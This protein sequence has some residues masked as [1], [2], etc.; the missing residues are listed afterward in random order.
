MTYPLPTATETHNIP[1]D[2]LAAVCSALGRDTGPVALHEPEFRGSEL[3]YVSDCIE[4]GWVSSV[5]KYVDRFEADLAS[6]T[7]VKRAVAVVNGTAALHIALKLVGVEPGDEVL[8]PSLTFIATANAVTYAGAVPHFVDSEPCS[9]GVDANAL[10]QHLQRIA[11]VEVGVCRNRETGARIK[12]LMPMHVFGHP[13]DVDAVYALCERWHLEFVE[14][15][16]ESLGSTYKGRHAGSFGRVAGLSFNGNKLVTTGGGGA[17]LTNDEELGRRAKHLT[18]T[19]KLPHKWSFVH[20]EVGYNYRMP[21]INAALG[22]AQLERLPDML[23]RKRQLAQRYLAAFSGVEGAA[24]LPTP[25]GTSSNYWLIAMTLN[26]P[27]VEL[28][29]QVLQLLNDNGFMARPV[30]TLLHK[31]PMFRNCP[32]AHLAVAENLEARIISLPSSP[33]LAD[34]PC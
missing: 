33:M 34:E 28:R 21:N 29:D 16:A 31:L 4:S 25:P 13:L 6:Y 1:R 24:I 18:T 26:E 9:M 32:K 7:G 30:W 2:V 3:A 12:A 10:E 22:C 14:D 15:A 23:D 5:G 17:I 11:I 27:D 19:A 20:D 8:I